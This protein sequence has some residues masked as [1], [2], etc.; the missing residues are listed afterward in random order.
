[1]F[2]VARRQVQWHVPSGHFADR[3][4]LV[5]AE[6]TDADA[7]RRAVELAAPDLVFHLASQ[8][9]VQASFADPLGTIENNT[10]TLVHLLDAVRAVT[11]GARVLVVSSGEVYGRGGG[12]RPIDEHMPLRPENPYAVSKC[13]QDLLGL[14]YHLAHRLAVVRV[15]PFN[16]LGPGQSD[17]FVASSFARQIAEIEAGQCAPVIQVGNLEAERDFTDVRDVV[18]AY[19]LALDNAEPGVAYNLGRGEGVAIQ[20]LLD[21]LVGECRVPV[22]VEVDPARMRPVDVPSLVCDA[23]LF[24][25]HTSWE[26]VIPLQVTL[27]DML[28]YWRGQLG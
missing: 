25:A 21:L 16:H 26:P 4:T 15:R 3:F 12:G 8:S 17:R 24:R 6:L 2:G 5:E 19:L 1:V 18:R 27:R 20:Q 13:V 7:T 9:S 23:S 10:A 28:D 14:Q 11:P 22:S